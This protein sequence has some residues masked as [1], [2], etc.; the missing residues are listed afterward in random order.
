MDGADILVG[1]AGKDLL[2]GG[3]GRDVFVFADVADSTVAA[4]GRDTIYDFRK[5][6]DRIQLSGIDA[7]LTMPGD[8][9]FRFSGAVHDG[10]GSLRAIVM[11]GN[12][13]IGG[14][15]NG[16]GHDDFRILISGIPALDAGD[17]I[18]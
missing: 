18:L 6:E 11:G 5:G 4:G 16:D 13:V 17:F 3:R 2:F 8:Q 14:D 10:P 9:A 12:T 15:L 1:G 7:D